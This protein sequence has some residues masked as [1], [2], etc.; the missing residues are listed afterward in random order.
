MNAQMLTEEIAALPEPAQKLV[1]DLVASLRQNYATARN[2]GS[3]APTLTSDWMTEP[4]FGMWR[5]RPEMQ[6]SAAYVRE[7]R[8]KDAELRRERA[9]AE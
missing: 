3:I 7:L 6:D 5:D 1:A 4:A 9:Q 2:D 8:E